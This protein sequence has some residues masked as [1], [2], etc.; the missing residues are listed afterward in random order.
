MLK[1]CFFV[2]HTMQNTLCVSL[3]ETH[4]NTLS[5]LMQCAVVSHG[6]VRL[7]CAARLVTRIWYERVTELNLK[8]NERKAQDFAKLLPRLKEQASITTTTTHPLCMAPFTP[9][10]LKNEIKK[11]LPDKS[12]GPFRS[13]TECYKPVTLIFKASFSFFPTVYGNLI[14]NPQTGN[15]LS[16][17]LSTIDT[18]RTK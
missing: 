16:Y 3:Y 17:N 11:P 10:E 14:H 8:D 18:A 12:P 5:L 6:P 15:F 4:C 7:S 13:L 1:N 2:Q 9:D